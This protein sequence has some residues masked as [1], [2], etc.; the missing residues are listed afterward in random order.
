MTQNVPTTQRPTNVQVVADIYAGAAKRGY[1]AV[2]GIGAYD[3]KIGD[4]LD[5]ALVPR[6]FLNRELESMA[7]VVRNE[8]GSEST[9]TIGGR[10]ANRDETLG[11]YRNSAVR[12]TTPKG[13]P[14]EHIKIRIARSHDGGA[15]FDPVGLE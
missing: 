1:T 9:I 11:S 5:T 8:Y 12:K 10:R 15:V 3:E 2:L 6:S 7:K 13:K 14:Y 4:L